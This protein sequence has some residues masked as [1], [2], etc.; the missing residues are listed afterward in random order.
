MAAKKKKQRRRARVVGSDVR[1]T[2]VSTRIAGGFLKKLDRWATLRD[3]T[4]STAV[5]DLLELGWKTEQ[6][7]FEDALNRVMADEQ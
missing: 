1:D 5:L 6:R 4:R 2:V 3:V 7:D